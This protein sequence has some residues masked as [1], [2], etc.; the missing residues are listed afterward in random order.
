MTHNFDIILIM[1]MKYYD[2]QTT[3]TILYTPFWMFVFPGGGRD[4]ESSQNFSQVT[5]VQLF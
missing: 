5:T 4:S 1:Y 3:S 2:V